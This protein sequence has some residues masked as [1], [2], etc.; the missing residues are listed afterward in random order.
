MEDP[1]YLRTRATVDHGSE[2]GGGEGAGMPIQQPAQLSGRAI[3]AYE[4]TAVGGAGGGRG[5][6]GGATRQLKE[7]SFLQDLADTEAEERDRSFKASS[8]VSTLDRVRGALDP[9]SRSVSAVFAVGM[10]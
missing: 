2:G 9:R 7:M 3:C 10:D 5:G 8:T 1:G 6:G 4:A